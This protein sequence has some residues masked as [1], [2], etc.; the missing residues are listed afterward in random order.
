[1]RKLWYHGRV[2]ADIGKF[3]T[4][5]IIK[6]APQGLYLDGG[7]NGEILLP[8]RY[9]P[10]GAGPGGRIEVFLYFDSEDRLIATTERP[11]AQV[12]EFAYLR[13]VEV[14]PVGA[15]LDWGL[16]K[17]LLVPYREQGHPPLRQGRSYG[18]F[19]YL[20]AASRRIVASARLAKFFDAEA[21]PYHVGQEVGLLIHES[22]ELGWKAIIENSR[23][24]VLYRNEV[25]RE[26]EPG[27]R[28]RGYIHKI[29]EDGKI[30]LR[31]DPP[32]YGKVAGLA[33][34]I[35]VKLKESGGFLGVTDR[36]S[37]EEI[38]ALFGASKKAFK[39]AVGAL[40]KRHQIELEPDGIRLKIGGHHT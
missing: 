39:M 3:N 37:P 33:E 10:L 15:F 28:L 21:P 29:R 7:E 27:M 19:I 18:V 6:T 11:L 8:R 40:Y 25:F 2:L 24:G 1:M 23:P 34:A 30:D 5:R 38:G 31:L 20:D 12:G 14:N 17:H 4:L 16:P 26:I 32:G 35:I 22:T 36:T 13:V 9:V